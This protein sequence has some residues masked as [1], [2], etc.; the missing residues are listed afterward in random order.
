MSSYM[1]LRSRKRYWPIEHV[2]KKRQKIASPEGLAVA[3]RATQHNF[4]S[5]FFRLPRELREVVYEHVW[6]HE[7]AWVF[8]CQ[9]ATI[10][11]SRRP[12]PFPHRYGLPL[13][14]LA[15]KVILEEAVG[16]L[17]RMYTFSVT[18][19]G[20]P[21]HRTR[22]N[23]DRR[24]APKNPV[25]INKNLKNLKL[26]TKYALV[27]DWHVASRL[28]WDP[29]TQVSSFI[30]LPERLDIRNLKIEV[31]ANPVYFDHADESYN[32]E[33]TEPLQVLCGRCKSMT[34]KLDILLEKYGQY[35]PQ[36]TQ[37]IDT[38]IEAAEDCAQRIVGS[39]MDGA[40][41]VHTAGG[42]GCVDGAG[43][44]SAH[45]ERLD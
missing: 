39:S 3:Q 44:I 38:A 28:Y 43:L 42:K 19:D 35:A 40:E 32:K 21:Q 5:S 12:Y 17:H 41:E 23:T 16:T 6:D 27:A 18:N 7:N 36:L 34:V 30:R 22:G 10:V 31:Q 8:R 24:A 37:F 26:I 14:M 45:L 25:L 13:W 29:L 11:V 4:A 2:P 1:Q 33:Y 20:Y 9:Q 15:S